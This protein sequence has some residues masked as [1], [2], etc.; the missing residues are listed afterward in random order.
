MELSGAYSFRDTPLRLSFRRYNFPKIDWLG[1]SC[2][3]V[4]TFLTKMSGCIN[5]K[6]Q[7]HHT[8]D[9]YGTG[10]QNTIIFM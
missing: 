3:L 8:Y 1:P 5:L 4:L 6:R 9:N 7:M 2:G 10:A